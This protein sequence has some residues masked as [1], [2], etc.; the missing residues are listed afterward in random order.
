MKLKFLFALAVV[1]AVGIYPALATTYNL[2][3]T[4]G[5]YN[6][7][8]TITTD[9]HLGVLTAANIT[10]W[11]LAVTAIG[12]PVPVYPQTP[13]DSVLFL[14]GASLSAT[15]T[16]LL[17]DYTFSLPVSGFGVNGT[18]FG[19]TT[20]AFGYTNN[21]LGESF[22]ISAC[23]I[24]NCFVSDAG[25]RRS[26]IQT[27]GVADNATTPLPGALSLFATGLGASGL[28]RGAG[29]RKQQQ[30]LRDQNNNL[31]SERPPRCGLSVLSHSGHR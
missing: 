1:G 16:A 25:P 10:D 29:K 26:G 22:G 2:N 28:L 4:D 19:D 17:F 24:S 23:F 7:T 18:V 13:S 5:V 31:I 21:G 8:G 6:L 12:F 30:S 15:S 11:N 14:N 27:I 9:G 3:D 20:V